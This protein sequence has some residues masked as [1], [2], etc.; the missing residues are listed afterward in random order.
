[1]KRVAV[2][3]TCLLGMSGCMTGMENV[4]VAPLGNR[5]PH[6][7][8]Q[9]Q[10]EGSIT[11]GLLKKRWIAVDV[12]NST[13]VAQSQKH[14]GELIVKFSPQDYLIDV[15]NPWSGVSAMQDEMLDIDYYIQRYAYKA[16]I[17][18]AKMKMRGE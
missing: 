18:S 1:M 7:L 16:A 4:Q 6:G 9:V 14:D 17:E 13:I 12:V 10:A 5:L 8:S 2:M 3:V 11:A 15:I